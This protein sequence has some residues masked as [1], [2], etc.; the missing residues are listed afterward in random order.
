MGTRRSAAGVPIVRVVAVAGGLECQPGGAARV[1][2]AK[3]KLVALGSSRLVPEGEISLFP[4]AVSLLIVK[5]LG[6]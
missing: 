4:A 2:V 1:N 5:P 3:A 6:K